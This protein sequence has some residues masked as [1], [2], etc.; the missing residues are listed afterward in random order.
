MKNR[1][2]LTL[3]EVV[4]SI[5]LINLIAVTFLG[6][7]NMGNKFIFKAGNKTQSIN[8]IK[9]KIDNKIREAEKESNESDEIKVT[10]PG[11]IE[12]YPVEGRMIEI[13]DGKD[14]NMKITTFIPNKKDEKVQE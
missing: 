14:P 7:F 4:L 1:K 8:E 6:M 3:I 5:A 9:R 13:K 2:A 10:I 12:Y 11:V